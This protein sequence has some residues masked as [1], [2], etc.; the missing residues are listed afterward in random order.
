MPHAK[1]IQFMTYIIY[2][3]IASVGSKLLNIHFIH[4]LNALI[5][6]NILFHILEWKYDWIEEGGENNESN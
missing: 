6:S 1:Q 4:I 3:I 5:L 2:A